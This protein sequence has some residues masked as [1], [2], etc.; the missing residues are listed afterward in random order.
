[1]IVAEQLSGG[2]STGIARRA[3]GALLLAALVVG[4][5]ALWVGVPVAVL[6]GLGKAVDDPGEHLVL[7]IIAVPI[8]MLAFGIV[9]ASVNTVYLRLNGALAPEDADDEWRPRLH[10]PLDRIMGISAVICL[11]AFLVWLLVG[12][13]WV[14]PPG[15]GAW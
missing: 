4:A 6:W 15:A 1:V 10:G 9:L 12:S 11:V 13:A 5:F 8:V 14:S 7:G 3:A 2:R